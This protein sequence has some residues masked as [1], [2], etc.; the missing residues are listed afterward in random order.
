M[1]NLLS[2]LSPPSPNQASSWRDRLTAGVRTWSGLGL[3]VGV[4]C[5]LAADTSGEAAPDPTKTT[6]YEVGWDARGPVA[7]HTEFQ[8][9]RLRHRS[10]Y[11]SAYR[12]RWRTD[13]PAAEQHLLR[14]INRLTRIHA[15]SESRLVFVMDEDLFDYPL[16]YA[17]EPG[18]WQFSDAEAARL[19]EYLL[20]GGFLLVDD[21]H[22]TSQWYGFAAGLHRILPDRQI[23]DIPRSDSVFHT[24]YDLDDPVQIPGIGAAMRGVTYERDGVTPHWRGIYDDH[25]RLMVVINFN[26]DLGDAWEHADVPEYALRYTNR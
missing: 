20:R 23:V 5:V 21:F 8:F 10:A 16:L 9:A 3:W 22:G 11:D 24:V 19:R 6:A 7:F 18:T 17:V 4:A 2:C 15:A 14:G 12:Q 1:R 26:M 25:G 13:W